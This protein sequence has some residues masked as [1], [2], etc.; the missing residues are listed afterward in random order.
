MQGLQ[1]VFEIISAQSEALAAEVIKSS[2]APLC[3]H[4]CLPDWAV[5]V[6]AVALH[7]HLLADLM[8]FNVGFRFR[9]LSPKCGPTKQWNNFMSGGIWQQAVLQVQVADGAKRGLLIS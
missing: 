5:Q 2:Q 9:L 8:H 3:A 7:S 6:V 4:L 1:H